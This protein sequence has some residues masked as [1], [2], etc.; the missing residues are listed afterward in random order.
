MNQD[1]KQSEQER[2]GLEL[3]DKLKIILD[4]VWHSRRVEDVVPEIMDLF[5][6]RQSEARLEL[7]EQL[8]GNREY[9][10]SKKHFVYGEWLGKSLL[11]TLQEEARLLR[12]QLEGNPNA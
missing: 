6:S 4:G 10:L 1:S 7:V 9:P 2:T 12:K 11:K 3:R 5:E 8:L